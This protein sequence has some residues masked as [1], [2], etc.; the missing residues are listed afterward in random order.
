MPRKL[1]ELREL[2]AE[3]RRAGFFMDHQTGSH[4]QW[5]HPALASVPITLSGRDGSDAKG[6]QEREI[7][8]VLTRLRTL[9]I[10]GNR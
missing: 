6:Y 1:R 10:E 4:E 7:L 5:R 2:R 3:L 8:K 9:G